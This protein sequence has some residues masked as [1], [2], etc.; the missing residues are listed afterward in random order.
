MDSQMHFHIR[1]SSSTQLDWQPFES[2]EE[3]EEAA[4]EMVRWNETYA[5]EERNGSCERCGK[6]RNEKTPASSVTI[7]TF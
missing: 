3:A 4:K 6:F 2:R 5:I 1:W 7:V